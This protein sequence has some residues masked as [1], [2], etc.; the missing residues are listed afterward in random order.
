MTEIF[1]TSMWSSWNSGF[2]S[3]F[4]LSVGIFLV[5][6]ISEMIEWI[7]KNTTMDMVYVTIMMFI[8]LNIVGMI[9]Y[10]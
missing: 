7:K 5:I 9:N 4:L 8:A 10:L 2:G 3:R 1:I 6:G